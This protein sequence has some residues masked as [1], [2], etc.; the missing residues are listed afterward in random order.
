MEF[1]EMFEESFAECHSRRGTG[2]CLTPAFELVAYA[3]GG[4]TGM[5]GLN[6]LIVSG[7]TST[8]ME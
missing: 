6:N 2:R 5:I 3:W 8:Q 1:D 7:F 4:G